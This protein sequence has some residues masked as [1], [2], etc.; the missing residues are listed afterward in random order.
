MA[1]LFVEIDN[2]IKEFELTEGTM[3]IGRHPVLELMPTPEQRVKLGN[4]VRKIRESKE[5]V[6]IDFWNDGEFTEGCIAWG[7]RYLH[8]QA[9]GYVEPCVFV[10]FAKDNIREKTLTEIVN[11]DCFAE[12][13]KLHP[14]SDDH[15]RPCSLIDNR[16]VL[17]YLA[18][19]Y[20][21]I[22]THD[23]ADGIIKPPL[24]DAVV[25]TSLEYEQALAPTKEEHKVPNYNAEAHKR[26]KHAGDRHPSHAGSARR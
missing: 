12:A 25:K 11:S 17:P 6:V 20:G 19:K 4:R 15:R 16:E 22:P 3:P 13:R 21:M 1:S 5:I 2:A 8:V 24:R 26:L 18:E 14:Y 7:R 23:G 9:T 10:H